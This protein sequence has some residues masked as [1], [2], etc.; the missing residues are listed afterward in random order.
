MATRNY[1]I[2]IGGTGARVIEAVVHLCAAGLGPD[3][4][5]MFMIDPDA[6]NGNL[7]RTKKLITEYK[8]CRSKLQKTEECHL[9]KTDIKI[10]PGE[11]EFVWEIFTNTNATLSD[12]INF[13]NLKNTNPDLSD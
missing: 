13:T 1:L 12:F 11:K 10:P 5:S 7:D 4:L 3:E 2:G 8:N 6:G 9:F